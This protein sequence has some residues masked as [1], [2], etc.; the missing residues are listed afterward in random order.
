MEC[1]D[2]VGCQQWFCN[3]AK[4]C[5]LNAKVDCWTDK[6]GGCNAEVVFTQHTLPPVAK[7]F[8]PPD[9]WHITLRFLGDAHAD[10]VTEAL[11]AC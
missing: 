6:G 8:V 4:T 11:E 9:N 5:E 2:F 3:N 1:G 7:R 10:D